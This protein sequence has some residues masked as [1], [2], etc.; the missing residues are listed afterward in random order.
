MFWLTEEPSFSVQ[1]MKMDTMTTP[2]PDFMGS[3]KHY[4]ETPIPRDP[5]KVLRKHFWVENL[6]KHKGQS[7]G[8]INNKHQYQ[9]TLYIEGMDANAVRILRKYYC[10]GVIIHW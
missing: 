9:V 3:C 5:H 6:L 8:N 2:G 4:Y 10:K 7:K 1:Q